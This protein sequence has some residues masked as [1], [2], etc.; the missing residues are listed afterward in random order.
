MLVC[1]KL[2]YNENLGMLKERGKIVCNQSGTLLRVY[3]TLMSWGELSW[4][5]SV[6]LWDSPPNTT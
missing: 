2:A 3:C 4:D 6:S 1:Q 5:L